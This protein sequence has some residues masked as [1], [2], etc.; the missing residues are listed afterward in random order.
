MTE[1]PSREARR[2]AMACGRD[3]VHRPGIGAGGGSGRPVRP[4]AAESEHGAKQD[5]PSF[6]TH[7]GRDDR[8]Q[9]V[10]QHLTR[11]LG[12]RPDRL[13]AGA[14]E[15]EHQ[16]VSIAG[17]VFAVADIE[18]EVV[19]HGSPRPLACTRLPRPNLEHLAGHDPVIPAD[20]PDYLARAVRRSR[21]RISPQSQTS[22]TSGGINSVLSPR[23]S[24]RGSIARSWSRVLAT[25][26]PGTRVP[27]CGSTTT[28]H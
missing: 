10:Q 20:L 9:P 23:V 24:P 21:P 18:V 13:A 17:D 28:A 11:D 26:S 2:P 22:T 12:Q 8:L 19:A 4:L 14:C 25:S 16:A 27:P 7:A 5:C 6:V 15:I 3:P 1:V